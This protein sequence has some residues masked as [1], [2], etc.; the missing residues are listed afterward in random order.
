VI[1]GVT[2]SSLT[3]QILSDILGSRT[4]HPKGPRRQVKD[5]GFVDPQAV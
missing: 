2:F 3:L 5:D 4:G 1:F